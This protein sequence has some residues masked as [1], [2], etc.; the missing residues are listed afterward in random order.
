MVTIDLIY[1]GNLRVN[2]THQPSSVQLSTD[3]PVDNQGKGE[4]FSPT[5]LVATALASCMLTT[6]GISA[7]EKDIPMDNSQAS[8]DKHMSQDAP[9]RISIL[10]VTIHIPHHL[11]DRQMTILHRAAETCPVAQSISAAIKVNFSLTCD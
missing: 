9:R 8:V 5:D 4:S 6:M 3:A 11:D 10:D 2:A 1:E 7:R